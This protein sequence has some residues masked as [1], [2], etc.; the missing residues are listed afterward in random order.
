[1]KAKRIV[2]TLFKVGL[3]LSIILAVILVLLQGLQPF[4]WAYYLGLAGCWA[5]VPFYLLLWLLAKYQIYSSFIP[6]SARTIAIPLEKI[7]VAVTASLQAT[8][9]AGVVV[10]LGLLILGIIGMRFQQKVGHYGI[11]MAKRR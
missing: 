3:T 1:M 8:V 5:T 10:A 6:Y 9:F 4:N 11:H 2:D 7:A